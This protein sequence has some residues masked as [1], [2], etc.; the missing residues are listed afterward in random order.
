MNR[1]LQNFFRELDDLIQDSEH[2]INEIEKVVFT[3]RYRLTDEHIA[4]FSVQTIAMLY[5]IWEGFIQNTFSKYLVT[6]NKLNI[7]FSD[8][9]DSLVIFHLESRFKQFKEYPE[10]TTKKVTF[11]SDLRNHFLSD[12]ISFSARVNTESNVSFE[13]L[14][15]IM[16][17]F[18]LEQ[19]PERWGDNYN[20]PNPTLKEK[21][22]SFLDYRN[23]VAHGGDI[24]SNDKVTQEVFNGYKKLVIDLMHG[25]YDKIYE[26]AIKKHYL[27]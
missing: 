11:F 6:L 18:A 8:C 20:Y 25:I 5:A 22:K 23:G 12:K 3:Q 21:M 2:T 1:E 4:I 15:K 9:Q 24:S 26:G 10:K 13:V 7:P 16:S 19:F 14:N 27:K 17:Q